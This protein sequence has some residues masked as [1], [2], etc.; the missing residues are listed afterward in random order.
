MTTTHKV[1]AIFGGIGGLER[2]LHRAGHTTTLFC[3]CDPDAASVLRRR[4]RDVPI[5]PDVRRTDEVVAGISPR[6]DLLTAG[7]PCTDL[8]QAGTTRGF[9]GGRS[10]LIRE[11]IDLLRKRPFPN[12]LIE[13]VPNWRHLHGGSYL[14]EVVNELEALGYRWAYRTL[15]ARAFGLAQRRL[16]LFLFA[17]LAGDPREVL[18]HGN[19]QPAEAAFPLTE[20]AHGF[21]WTEGSRGLGW[22]EDCVPT[23]K[24]GSAI[25]IPAP[26]AI[27]LPDL[28][29]ITP[30]IS[31]AERL[32]GLQPGWTDLRERAPEVGGGPF[33][34]RRRWLLVGNAINVNV[35]HWL[36]KG[37]ARRRSYSGPEGVPLL[38]S[39]AWPAAAWFDGTSRRAVDL[40]AWPVRIAAA[41]LHEFLAKPGKPLSLRATEG[42]YNRFTHSR[43]SK[44][45]GFVEALESHLEALKLASFPVEVPP[46][47]AVAA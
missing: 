4:F 1:T 10:S 30:D 35:G 29:L 20:A 44:P 17:C 39:A 2:G 12:I 11:T 38:P 9:S 42:F 34:Q 13:N 15:D 36:G 32:Q 41:P 24:G 46:V 16:R 8:S 14:R 28:R 19:E 7:F 5:T 22:G 47:R 37:L 25:G 45:P 18:F 3:E 21:Y 23:L 26:P 6:S 31:D 43:L 27:L 40:S 33:N